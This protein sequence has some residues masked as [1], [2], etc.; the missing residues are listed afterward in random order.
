[1]YFDYYDFSFVDKIDK[2][3]AIDSLFVVSKLM[4]T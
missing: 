2:N 4:A 3:Y 1:M